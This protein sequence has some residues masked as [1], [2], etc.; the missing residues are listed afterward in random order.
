MSSATASEI[1]K[2]ESVLRILILKTFEWR[3]GGDRQ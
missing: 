2:H 1:T 3:K